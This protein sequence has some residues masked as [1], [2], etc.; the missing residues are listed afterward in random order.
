MRRARNKIDCQA[1]IDVHILRPYASVRFYIRV[2]S[3]R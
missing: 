2:I 3:R 1:Q